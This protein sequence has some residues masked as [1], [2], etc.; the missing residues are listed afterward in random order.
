[1]L[2]LPIRREPRANWFA[3][4]AQIGTTTPTRV[5]LQGQTLVAERDGPL[6]LYVNDAIVPCL[7]WDCLYRNNAGGPARVRVTRMSAGSA[8][9]PALVPYDC[10]E[11]AAVP[12]QTASS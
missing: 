1:M 6:S 8:P 7:A 11:Q 10:T 4:I 5:P 3:V 12:R 9:P 2:A